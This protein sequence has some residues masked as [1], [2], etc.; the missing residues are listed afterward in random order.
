MIATVTRLA[1]L[2]L[3]LAVVLASAG[4]GLTL[5]LDPP[6]P[7]PLDAGGGM[8]ADGGTDELDA[9][10]GA[11]GGAP[12]AGP[13]VGGCGGISGLVEAFDGP[14]AIPSWAIPA[15]PFADAGSFIHD[16]SGA[17]RMRAV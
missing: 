2:A 9:G 3:G 16:A 10:P 4:C 11:E 14:E 1:L 13:P 5:D 7:E 6:D 15:P 8:T 17:L 12:D